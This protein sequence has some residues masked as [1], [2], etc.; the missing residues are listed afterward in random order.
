MSYWHYNLQNITELRIMTSKVTVRVKSKL[1]TL[2]QITKLLFF[3]KSKVNIIVKC[4]FKRLKLKMV[5]LSKS[6][7]KIPSIVF[8]KNNIS[9]FIDFKIYIFSTF[10]FATLIQHEQKSRYRSGTGQIYRYRK[11]TGTSPNSTGTGTGPN[12]NWISGRVL[13]RTIIRP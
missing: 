7:V 4:W 1:I 12:R 3:K 10:L 2:R 6:E 9:R 8:H 11:G 5:Q 13:G